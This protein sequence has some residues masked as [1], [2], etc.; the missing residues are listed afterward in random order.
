MRLI[1]QEMRDQYILKLYLNTAKSLRRKDG[2][3]PVVL[4]VY[5]RNEPDAKKRRRF[6]ITPFGFP[7]KEEFEKCYLKKAHNY[8]FEKRQLDNYL[9]DAEAKAASLKYFTFSELSVLLKKPT[10]KN[11]SITSY[12]NSKISD[13]KENG[14][15]GT[16]SNYESSL[17]SLLDFRKE[18]K[19]RTSEFMFSEVDAKFLNQYESWMQANDKSNTTIG[20]YLRPLRAIFNAAKAAD[21]ELPYPFK[22]GKNGGYEIPTAQKTNKAL[23][24][25]EL[26]TL[27][28]GEPLS[29]EQHR[30]KAF[31]F[32][33][34][35]SNG[36]NMMDIAKLKHKDIKAD[37]FKF[38][39]SKT[40]RTTKS[41]QQIVE[42]VLLPFQ[43]EAI[44][45][46][47][48][49]SKTGYVFPII[50]DGQNEEQQRIK[51][52]AFTRTINHY[53][54]QY[55]KGL[56]IEADIS[57]NWARHSFASKLMRDNISVEFI[58]QSL[59]H[60]NI[61]TTQKYLSSFEDAEKTENAN[62]LLNF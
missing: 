40:K 30:A 14:Q 50:E 60:A 61:S 48:T 46:Y 10:L 8:K 23:T 4:S 6:V 38:V 56:G 2:N 28:E 20:I 57:T 27:F 5:N 39:R 18:K 36:M 21:E 37:R 16:A 42:V 3:F 41:H 24:S 32:F 43:Q 53:L 29:P 47:G 62:S 59:G 55:A 25:Q 49:K 17:N 51:V 31:F 1:F 58:R 13:F 34:Y 9:E 35:L 26:K 54:K 45:Q 44:N 7:S 52:Q 33:A 11:G 15:I 12:Y 22:K 19:S